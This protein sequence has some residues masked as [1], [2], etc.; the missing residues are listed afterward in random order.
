MLNYEVV[1][2]WPIE[3]VTQTYDE[4]D[5]MLYSLGLGLGGD[6]M[7][8]DQ[9]RYVYEKNLQ[10]MPTCAAAFA[11]PKSWMRDPRTGIDYLK[12]V[13]GE[14]DVRF[15]RPMPVAGTIVSKTRVSRISDKGAGKGAIVELMRDIIDASTGEQLA[16]VRQVSFLR[17]DGGFSTE[18]GVSDAP[19][20]A[21]PPVPERAPDAEYV[22]STGANAALIYRLSGDAN[23]LH[24]DPEV[25][26]KAGFSRP[27]LHGLAT[28]G[29][30]GYAAIRLLAGNDATRLKRLALRLT[31]PVYPG[32]EVRFQFWRDSDTRQHVRARVDA[33]DVV[34]L[35]NG[36]VEIA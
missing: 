20:E 4:R 26:A 32:E 29:M 1:K 14:Q 5:I 34:V 30:A 19:P 9:L 31:S 12:L 13:H 28:Y 11:W 27:I 3:D 21:L 33:R 23:P 25:A 18:S 17:G 8:A 22:L 36:I 15:V 24:A 7:D 2:N 35:N 16:E 10:A 6:P